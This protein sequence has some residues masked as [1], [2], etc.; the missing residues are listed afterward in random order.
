MQLE[1]GP[2]KEPGRTAAA[3][4]ASSRNSPKAQESADSGGS[5]GGGCRS[6]RL[7]KAMDAVN[8]AIFCRNFAPYRFWLSSFSAG[9]SAFAKARY[10]SAIRRKRLRSCPYFAL[11]A[12]PS[13]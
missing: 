7:E 10:F 1:D 13:K 6:V 11:F 2:S 5:R 8:A 3:V 4:P 9:E 12:L